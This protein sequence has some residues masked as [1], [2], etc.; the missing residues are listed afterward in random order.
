MGAMDVCPFIPVANTTIEEC[1]QCSRILGEQLA[2]EL[3]IPV[4]L[5]EVSQEK[6]YRKRLP[7]IRKGE[8]EGLKDKVSTVYWFLVLNYFPPRAGL[9]RCTEPIN[10]SSPVRMEN[11][12]ENS[13]PSIG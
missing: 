13:F 4:Y 3:N 6:E 10:K 9:D 1:V 7:D 8:Y 2:A 11:S 5:Y 12:E